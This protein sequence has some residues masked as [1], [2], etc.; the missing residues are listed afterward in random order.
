MQTCSLSGPASSFEHNY[1]ALIAYLL[2]RSYV[3]VY[4]YWHAVQTFIITFS[5]LIS[6]LPWIT[7]C[8][9]LPPVTNRSVNLSRH[10]QWFKPTL[11]APQEPPGKRSNRQQ[12]SVHRAEG[13]T[14][15]IFCI[16]N[17]LWV[18]TSCYLHWTDGNAVQS[19]NAVQG[20]RWESW[21]EGPEGGECMCES[22]KYCTETPPAAANVT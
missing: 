6:A 16:I 13:A 3:H 17:Y 20:P 14:S 21:V 11:R 4:F 5:S 2:L 9:V 7:C 19:S 15:W 1:K 18:A 8:G 22:V 12:Y 10:R